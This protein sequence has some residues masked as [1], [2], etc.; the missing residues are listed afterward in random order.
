MRALMLGWE[1]PPFITGG[2]GTACYGLTQA[3]EQLRTEILFLLPVAADALPAST[4]APATVSDPATRDEVRAKRYVTFQHVPSRVPNPYQTDTSELAVSEGQ[5]PS[6]C[7]IGAGAV[8]G[9]DGNLVA[10]VWE[11]AQRC[12]RLVE[13]E[14]FDV[15]HAHDWV[16]FPAG[17]LIARRSGKPLVVHV[18]ATE[19]DRSGLSPNPAIYNIEHQ[20]IHAASMVLAVS[21]MTKRTI[22]ERY[23][24]P[25]SKV[26]VVYNGIANGTAQVSLPQAEPLRMSDE[27]VVLFLGRITTQKGP[28]YF[29]EA[30]AAVL[31]QYDNVRF[32][33]AGWGDLAPH[34]I[35]KVAAMGLG[36]KIFFAGF[37]AG[38]QVERAYRMADVYVMPSVSEPFGLTALE[39]IQQGVPVIVSKTSGVAEVVDRGALKV[40]F[41][42]VNGLADRIIAVLEHRTLADELRRNGM[43]EIQ[44]LTWEA[45]AQQ[46]L[47]A[48]EGVLQHA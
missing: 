23:R 38:E 28:D 33:I 14:P 2:L 20:G 25:E 46:C 1:F 21:A 5:R 22:V 44:G 8:G 40:D 42:D 31:K 18:H 4:A 36:H 13:D 29:V 41:W 11:Y 34:I 35:E 12:A 9:Y 16:T 15:I 24:V 3:M 39:A 37:L 30:A 6:L 27:K 48:Y 47:R 26:K 43:R 7:V 45:T 19:F 17:V 10:R 32:I